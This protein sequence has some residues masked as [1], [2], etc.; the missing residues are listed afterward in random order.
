MS[1]PLADQLEAALRETGPLSGG[2]LAAHVRRR[3]ASVYRALH[4]DA[5]F[6]WSGRRRASRWALAPPARSSTRDNVPVVPIAFRDAV[7]RARSLGALDGIEAIELLLEPP[8]KV[9]AMLA[10]VAA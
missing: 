2:A 7:W 1:R 3:R 5:R 6:A 9:L 8:P 4:A 10:E